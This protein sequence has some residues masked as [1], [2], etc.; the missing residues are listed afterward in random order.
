MWS[1]QYNQRITEKSQRFDLC[2]L[3]ISDAILDDSWSK[4][5]FS[6]GFSSPEA[7]EDA[8]WTQH[9]QQSAP[10]CTGTSVIPS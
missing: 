2:V 10:S 3:G 4:M 6:S 8:A 5:T 7:V 9:F 1:H